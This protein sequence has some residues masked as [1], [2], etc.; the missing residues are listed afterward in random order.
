[1][2]ILIIDDSSDALDLARTRLAKEC[3][4]ILC[5]EGGI[6][7]LEVARRENPDLILLDLDMPDMSG[8]DVCRVLKADADLCMIPVRFPV[9]AGSWPFTRRRT[10]LRQIA[11]KVS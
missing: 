5:A 4:D 8:F 3:L 6:A 9:P 10:D 2:K 7:G 11:S 1:M